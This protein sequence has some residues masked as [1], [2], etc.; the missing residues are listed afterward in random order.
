MPNNKIIQRYTVSL[1]SFLPL[2][3][4]VE[5]A[6]YHTKSDKICPIKRTKHQL[7]LKYKTGV[8]IPS[9]LTPTRE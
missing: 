8:L 2:E 3:N 6:E 5:I 7:N 9:L 1:I 4:A